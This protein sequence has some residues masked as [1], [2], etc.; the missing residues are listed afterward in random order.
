MGEL[1]IMTDHLRAIAMAVVL[2]GFLPTVKAVR[3]DM[4]CYVLVLEGCVGRELWLLSWIRLFLFV[5]MSDWL[6][7]CALVLTLFLCPAPGCSLSSNGRG[8]GRADSVF[9]FFIF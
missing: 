6:V 4:M 3:C 5:C 9:C 1:V 8:C 7:V 2:C